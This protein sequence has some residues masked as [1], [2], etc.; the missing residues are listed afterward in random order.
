[1]FNCIKVLPF[2]EFSLIGKIITLSYNT[3]LSSSNLKY[4]SSSIVFFIANLK[5]ILKFGGQLEI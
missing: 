1:M 3:L 4:K 5:I 2:L